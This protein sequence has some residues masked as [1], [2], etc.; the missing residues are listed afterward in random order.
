MATGLSSGL[1]PRVPQQVR[2]VVTPNEAADA[3]AV[4]YPALLRFAG[5]QLRSRHLDEQL[6]EDLV[7]EAIASWFAAGG[8]LRTTAE[9]NAYLRR[10]ITNRGINMQNRRTDIL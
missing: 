8:K 9:M 5:N 4:L 1:T 2:G 3:L 6:A 10:A 7:Q